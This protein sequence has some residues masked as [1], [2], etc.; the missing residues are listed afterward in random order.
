M[1]FLESH[2]VSQILLTIKASARTQSKRYYVVGATEG[3]LIVIECKLV[4]R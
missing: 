4:E 2:I 1:G 3:M